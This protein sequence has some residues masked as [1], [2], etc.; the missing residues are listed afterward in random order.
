MSVNKSFDDAI[1]IFP[2]FIDG[3][4]SPFFQPPAATGM[5]LSG[6][7]AEGRRQSAGR[8]HIGGDRSLTPRR[9]MMLR[10]QRSGRRVAAAVPLQRDEAFDQLNIGAV[11]AVCASRRL[12][13]RPSPSDISRNSGNSRMRWWVA[14]A[15]IAVSSSYYESDVTVQSRISWRGS[16]FS[17]RRS[18]CS[19]PS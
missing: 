16:G 1:G 17:Q 12:I 10:G 9:N 7:G 14:M 18:A 5:A 6:A 8:R 19:M 4:A 3:Y 2:E 13:P 15:A 11:Q